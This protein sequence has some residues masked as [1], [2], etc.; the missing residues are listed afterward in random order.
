MGVRFCWLRR[1]RGSTGNLL[2]VAVR[3]TNA[4]DG[5]SRGFVSRLLRPHA[6]HATLESSKARIVVDEYALSIER[7]VGTGVILKSAAAVG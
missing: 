2:G 5:I 7:L 4:N 1:L 3:D 6:V